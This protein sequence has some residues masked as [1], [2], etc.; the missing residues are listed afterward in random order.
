MT[1]KILKDADSIDVTAVL[2]SCDLSKT[3]RILEEYD[4]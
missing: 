4:E 2:K 1:K 3:K